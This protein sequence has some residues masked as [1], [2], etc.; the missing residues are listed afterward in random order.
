MTQS[1]G[2][3]G[4]GIFAELVQDYLAGAFGESAGSVPPRFAA[5]AFAGDRL[6]ARAELRR[7]LSAGRVVV[8]NRYVSS[9]MA[10]Q[11]AKIA[12]RADRA[13]FYE[14]VAELEY[15]VLGLPRPDREVF[16]DVPPRLS[17]QL[18]EQRGSGDIHEKDAAH[19]RAAAR[20]YGELAGKLP[21]WKLWMVR[22]GLENRSE[23]LI[24]GRART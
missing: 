5:L 6:E 3:T 12:S 1:A 16:L 10:H 22:F 20:N 7:W 11:G 23:F 15:D 14:W 19:L 24:P 13:A 8:A 18:V 9:N 2:D 4:K 17:V 21:G